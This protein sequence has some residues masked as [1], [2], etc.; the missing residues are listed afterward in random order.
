MTKLWWNDAAC[1]EVA[2]VANEL[3][4]EEIDC[5]AYSTALEIV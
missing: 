5:L 1:G 3:D 4:C 2:E